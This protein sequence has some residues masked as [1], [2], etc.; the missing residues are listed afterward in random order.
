MQKKEPLVMRLLA[1]LLFSL[2][3]VLH[4][5]AAAA[6]PVQH[7]E[8]RL[9]SPLADAGAGPV[10]PVAVELKIADGWKTYWRTP[11]DAGLA[12][13]FDWAGSVNVAETQVRWPAPHRF[14]AFDLD[15]FGYGDKVVFPVD[16]TS[17]EAGKPVALSLKLDL[18]VCGDICVPETHTLSLSLP[19]GSGAAS[20]DEALYKEALQ[21]IPAPTGEGFVLRDAWLDV[22]HE[23]RTILTVRAQAAAAPGRGADLFVEN[24]AGIIFGKTSVSYSKKE[25]TAVFRAAA[26]T[27]EP[28]EKIAADL[29]GQ[30]IALTYVDGGTAVFGD[31]VVAERPAD[32]PPLAKP[33]PAPTLGW[34]LL[35]FA[36][37]GGL[38][39]NLMPCVLPVLSLKVLSVV[40][41][42]GKENR[43]TIFGNFMASAA[44]IIFSFLVMALSLIGFKAAGTTIGWGIQFQHPAF[45]V[46]LIVT[47]LIFASSMWGFFD[48]PLPRFIAKNIPAK[49]EHEPTLLGHFLTGAFATLLATPCTAP[50]LGTAVGFALARGAFEILTIFSFLGLGLAFPYVLL[51]VSPGIFK[52]MP[53]PG[54]WMVTLK[55]ILSLALAVTALWLANV[56]FTVTTT[57]TLDEGWQTFDAALIAPAVAEGKVVVVDVTADWCLTCKANKRLVMEQKDVA[58]A[59]AGPEILKLQA[60]WTHRDEAVAAYLKSFGKYGIPFNV[61]Y[62]PA[63]PEGIV[64]PEL[65]TKRA[66]RDALAAAAGE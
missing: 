35:F 8:A 53:R 32:A 19:E 12:P 63:A 21:K 22:D 66:V 45:L 54:R 47:L 29:K 58:E 27:Q 41:H 26:H 39:L 34:K 42:G 1:A 48:I 13:V 52:Y 20:A 14:T 55:K 23:N 50:F 40:S 9:F 43:M 33:L 64:L 57:P 36:F 18:L 24:A 62:G 16:I 59:L 31:T 46:F 11:G 60:D 5:G 51:A 28:F 37:L 25:K 3:L 38:I 30:G 61:I 49:H 7:V 44:G 56:L 10:V 6:Q 17:A 2:V 15:N 65:L 4:G